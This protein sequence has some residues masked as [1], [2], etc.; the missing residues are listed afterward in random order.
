[1]GHPSS[2]LCLCFQHPTTRHS[3][4]ISTISCCS[5]E[6][7]SFSSGQEDNLPSTSTSPTPAPT[8]FNLFRGASILLKGLS[9]ISIARSTALAQKSGV[10]PHTTASP[11]PVSA[12]NSTPMAPAFPV[13]Q[14]GATAVNATHQFALLATA[15]ISPMKL[16]ASFVMMPGLAASAVQLQGA[17]VATP[18]IH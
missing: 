10:I 6:L 7:R 16:N 14:Y 2:P 13:I 9:Y 15:P 18:L 5:L 11:F 12:T 17:L 4:W 3:R 1:M 8:N